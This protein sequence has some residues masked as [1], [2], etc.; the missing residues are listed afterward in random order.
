MNSREQLDML[1]FAPGTTGD[2]RYT[3]GACS[4]YLYSEAYET[5]VG[6]PAICYNTKAVGACFHW[7]R[8][9]TLNAA[10]CLKGQ[11]CK[12]ETV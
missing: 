10:G 5:K 12:G 9:V 2:P 6:T 3:P 7:K 1:G 4:Q 11:L 8:N